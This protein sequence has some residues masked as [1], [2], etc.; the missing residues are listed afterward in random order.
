MGRKTVLKESLIVSCRIEGDEYQKLR[1]IAALESLS[2]GKTV[3][4]QSLIRD[5]VRY[6]YSDNER[7]R[8]GES[9]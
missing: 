4:V 9:P 7:L 6:V 1:D 3:T 5:A 2:T 8:V